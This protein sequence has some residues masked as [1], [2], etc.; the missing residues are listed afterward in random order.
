M[1]ARSKILEIQLGGSVDVGFAKIDMVHANHTIPSGK[2]PYDRDV[3]KEEATDSSQSSP[4][5]RSAAA[6]STASSNQTATALSFSGGASA[7][8]VIS[9]A[10]G[11]PTIYHTGD[12]NDFSDFDLVNEFYRPTHVLLPLGDPCT[13]S[14]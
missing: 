9:I 6:M 4:G 14:P 11:G 2:S 1:V 8:W 13:L 5:G 12:T 3:M 10:N 7:G